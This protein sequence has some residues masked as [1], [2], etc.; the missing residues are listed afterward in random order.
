MK[1]L[2]P[3]EIGEME[4]T[5]RQRS[6]ARGW[7]FA[8]LAAFSAALLVAVGVAIGR[9]TAP[10]ESRS[11]AF[12][13]DAFA[14][15]WGSGDAN[16]IRAFYTEDAVVIPFGHMLNALS[17]HPMPEYWDV[18]GP[19]MDREAGQHKGGT[20]T[21]LEAKQIGDMMVATG[22]WTFPEGLFPTSADTVIKATDIMHLRDGKIWRQFTDFQ[23]YVDGKL[24]DVE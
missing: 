4:T 17:S 11:H 10:E 14:A 7:K 12:D 16:Q 19:A 5:T 3:H 21:F 9:V 2:G 13:L 18:S 8:L 22:Q 6:T 15:A 24:T 1:T 20:Y 23:V